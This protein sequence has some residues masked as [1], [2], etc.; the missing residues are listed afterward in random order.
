M[1]LFTTYIAGANSSFP[2]LLRKSSH[3]LYALQQGMK[4]RPGLLPPDPLA[5]PF[6][7][8]KAS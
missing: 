2:P 7:L 6:A 4:K 5:C 1:P 3:K 8:L